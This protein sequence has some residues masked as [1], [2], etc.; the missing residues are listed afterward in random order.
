MQTLQENYVYIYSKLINM[1]MIKGKKSIA[2]QIVNKSI[3]AANLKLKESNID[4]VLYKAIF[5]I[6]PDIKIKA[7]RKGSMVYQIPV[8]IDNKQKFNLGIRFFL[9]SIKLRKENTTIERFT[10]E[11]ID[12]Y[13]KKGLSIKKKDDL[14]KIAELN[15]SLASFK[16]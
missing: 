3:L 7:K 5:N 14:H 13:N 4:N 16:S 1:L 6:S 12:A 2:K 9:K 8:P 15:K 11:L 10:L